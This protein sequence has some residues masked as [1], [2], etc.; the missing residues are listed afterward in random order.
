MHTQE[1]RRYMFLSDAVLQKLLTVY[2][3][4]DF[5]TE[6]SPVILFYLKEGKKAALTTHFIR[7]IL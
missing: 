6:H 2:I 1:A 4:T 5:I 3:D 7:C